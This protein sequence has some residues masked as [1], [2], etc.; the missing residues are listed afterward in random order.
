MLTVFFGSFI[1]GTVANQLKQ[2]LNDPSSVIAL[3]GAAAPQ[4]VGPPP[5]R[6]NPPPLGL[7]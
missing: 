5:Q 1:A 6:R 3:L 4:T 2:L 7:P